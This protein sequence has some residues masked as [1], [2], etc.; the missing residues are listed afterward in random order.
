MGG[1]ED[2]LHHFDY[3]MTYVGSHTGVR[4]IHQNRLTGAEMTNCNNSYRNA[5]YVPHS[6]TP[7]IR[8]P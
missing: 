8:R 3:C 4:G 2:P 1:D 6:I 5:Q 7:R